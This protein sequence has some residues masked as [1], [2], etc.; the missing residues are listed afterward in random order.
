[1]PLFGGITIPGHP[2]PEN[3]RRLDLLPLP[4]IRR[5][6]R[7]GM[8]VD[9]PW[10][11]DLSFRL[12]K[13]M[14]ELRGEILDC[15]PVEALEK[16]VGLSGEEI[17]INPESSVQISELL[18]EELGLGVGVRIKRTKGGTRLTTG[19]K[20][21]EQLKKEHPVVPLI[22]EYREAS[23]L[24]GTYTDKMPRVAV[25]HEGRGPQG[26]WTCARC[27]RK[28]WEGHWRIHT[29]ILDTRTDTGRMASK[30]PNLQNIPA[31]TTL[32][33]EVR[34]AF[35][36]QM[37][38]RLVGADYSG[39]ELRLLS[40]CARE[41]NMI[42]LFRA[43]ADIHTSTAMRAFGLEKS[44]VDKTL[45]RA[46]CKN[47]NFGIVYGLG[48]EGLLD[49]M[50][51]TYATANKPM[52]EWMDLAW[53]IGFMETWF[54]LYPDVRAYLEMQHERARR[55]GFVWTPMGRVRLVPEVRSVHER[56]VAAGLRQAGNMPIQGF[57][58]DIMRL[59]MAIVEDEWARLREDGVEVEALMTIH[60]E[61]LT[62]V[63]EDWA[64]GLAVVQPELMKRALV[65]VET[66]KEQCLVGI[67][68][69]GKWMERWEK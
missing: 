38:C 4:Q 61:I 3:I 35:V 63:E 20:A 2:S 22:L 52:P 59:G 55:Y 66:G 39:I 31:R 54:G 1:M 44:E 33:A 27:G 47:L 12:D 40:H 18:Y 26:K 13:R 19:K 42:R 15:V 60:D 29:S 62:E 28:H 10:L 34:R 16:F 51:L 65:D 48:P 67:E 11:Q 45:H 68:A 21:L 57:S 56:V 14:E 9:L 23:K 36:P 50:A 24:K 30:N 17:G 41:W 46:P 43:G 25:W 69:E 37:G 6:Q 7:M 5:M 58:A 49:Q 32:G 8:A 64:E 53:C